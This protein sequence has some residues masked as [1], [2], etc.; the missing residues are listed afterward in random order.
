MENKYKPETLFRATTEGRRIGSF[1]YNLRKDGYRKGKPNFI[2]DVTIEIIGSNLDKEQ[3]REL[4]EIII[5]ALNEKYTEPE[6]NSIEEF[7]S[8]YLRERHKYP[9]QRDGQ[10][11]FNLMYELNP[12]AAGKLTGSDIDPFNNDK[13]IDAFVTACFSG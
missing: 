7:Y 9:Q 5:S 6:V 12:S 11:V 2:N 10:F 1:I 8:V 3:Y 13:N 4:E